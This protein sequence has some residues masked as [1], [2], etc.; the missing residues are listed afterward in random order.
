M[1]KRNVCIYLAILL[2]SALGSVAQKQTPPPGGPPKPFTVPP[3]TSFTLPN[4]LRVT[5]V[6][7]GTVPKVTVAAVVRAGNLNEGADQVWLADITGDMIKEGTKTRTA[8]EVAQQVAGMGGVI[9][10]NVGPDQT[11][12]T[13]DVLSEFGPK[14]VAVLADVLENP[15]LPS[16]ELPRL[17]QD[18]LRKL[19]I[20]KTQPQ[21]IATEAFRRTLYPNH[22]Y[23]RVFP[24]ED[25][26]NKYSVEDVH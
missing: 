23:G 7:Y 19:A 4:G 2:L 13:A 6:P 1:Q 15:L 11:R 18:A 25:M 12:F 17:K 14:L 24:T 22:P 10:V 16:S 9:D 8:E 26:I 21:Q 20:D 5:M 3:P